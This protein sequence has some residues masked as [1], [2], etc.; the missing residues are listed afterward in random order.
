MNLSIGKDEDVAN[1]QSKIVDRSLSALHGISSTIEP[2]KPTSVQGNGKG[3]VIFIK[4]KFEN[5]CSIFSGFSSERGK[6]DY[7]FERDASKVADE[8][9][10]EALPYLSCDIA[11][12]PV[13]HFL[14]DQ[15][16]LPLALLGGGRFRYLSPKDADKHFVTNVSVIENFLGRIITT[17]IVEGGSSQSGVEVEVLHHSHLLSSSLSSAETVLATDDAP[18]E[19]FDETSHAPRERFDETSPSSLVYNST[20]ASRSGEDGL[21]R[22]RMGTRR[23]KKLM[24][25]NAQAQLGALKTQEGGGEGGGGDGGRGEGGGGIIGEGGGEDDSEDGVEEIDN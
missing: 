4:A 24:K 8:A 18:R 14:A 9:L 22:K 25:K 20:N 3:N 1:I 19:R 23:R 10:R 17:R 15:L 12:A 11:A 6:R 7:S 16:L 13:H 5:V 21:K 2:S